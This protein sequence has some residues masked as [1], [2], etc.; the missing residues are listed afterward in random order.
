[1]H[2]AEDARQYRTDTRNRGTGRP[3]QRRRQDLRHTALPSCLSLFGLT[4]LTKTNTSCLSLTPPSTQPANLDG[5]PGV[6]IEASCSCLSTPALRSL[7]LRSAPS[8]HPLSLQATFPNCCD[9]KNTRTTLLHHREKQPASATRIFACL[10][11][12]SCCALW[13]LV[14]RRPRPDAG[15]R[16]KSQLHV[17]IM[18]TNA[19]MCAEPCH[20]PLLEDDEI[21]CLLTRA[22]ALIRCELTTN[23]TSHDNYSSKRLWKPIRPQGTEV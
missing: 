21:H 17:F 12:S 11:R 2:R 19:S 20:P 22:R 23:S 5:V 14:P 18:Q 1:M 7:L 16:M 8:R 10:M 4:F 15:H 6:L 9:A 3:E 13:H